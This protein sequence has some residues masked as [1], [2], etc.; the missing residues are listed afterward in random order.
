MAEK[1][2]QDIH[3]IE[4]SIEG[5]GASGKMLWQIYITWR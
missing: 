4:Q 2:L 3:G 1:A 5:H